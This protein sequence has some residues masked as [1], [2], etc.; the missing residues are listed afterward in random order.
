MPGFFHLQDQAGHTE[1]WKAA[2]LKDIDFSIVQG[3]VRRHMITASVVPAVGGDH[4]GKIPFPDLSVALNAEPASPLI[5]QKVTY[6]TCIEAHSPGD[7]AAVDKSVI[8][9]NVRIDS[10]T[11]YIDT[12]PVID[13]DEI[14]FMDAVFQTLYAGSVEIVP[15]AVRDKRENVTCTDNGVQH[16]VDGAVPS[17]C[18]ND[19]VFVPETGKCFMGLFRRIIDDK[20]I[21]PTQLFRDLPQFF[22][23][24]IALIVQ[25]KPVDQI[26]IMQHVCC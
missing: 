2:C 1:F 18:R 25:L 20:F 12:V 13:P 9:C 23:H 26:Y 17:D 16:M 11:C 15:G 19:I 8:I 5:S 4:C 14:D 21:V 6:D 24:R 3:A 10:K 7:P 22:H